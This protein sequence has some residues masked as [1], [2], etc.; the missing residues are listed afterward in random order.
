MPA[1]SSCITLFVLSCVTK[2]HRPHMHHLLAKR[3][4]NSSK[5]INMSNKLLCKSQA[6][7]CLE[8]IVDCRHSHSHHPHEK[9]TLLRLMEN[10]LPKWRQAS[11]AKH[12]QYEKCHAAN[13]AGLTAPRLSPLPSSRQPR[14]SCP[15]AGCTSTHGA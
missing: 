15:R 10:L 12:C 14:P 3:L 13:N 5:H 6:P 8:M 2:T 4:Q 11:S 1:E 7:T 9:H